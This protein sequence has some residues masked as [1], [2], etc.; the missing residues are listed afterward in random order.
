MFRKSFFVPYNE[1]WVFPTE[2]KAMDAVS[3]YC[4]ENEWTCSFLGNDEAEI[5]GKVYTIKRGIDSGSRG[6]YGITC[7][8][9]KEKA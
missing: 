1:P 8:Q 5:N 3:A 9:K 2:L 4:A 7:V 6:G